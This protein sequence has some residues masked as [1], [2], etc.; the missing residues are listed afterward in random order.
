MDVGV[1]GERLHRRQQLR[2]LQERELPRAEV[3]DERAERLGAQRD[4]RAAPVGAV[5]VERRARRSGPGVLIG[6][7]RH[8]TCRRW[9]PLP[10]GSPRPRAPRSRARS[11]GAPI[12]ADGRTDANCRAAR[13]TRGEP[14]GGRLPHRA[15]RTGCARDP[16]PASRLPRRVAGGAR[17]RRDPPDGRGVRA[18]VR[19]RAGGGG[20]QRA[21]RRPQRPLPAGTRPR[22]HPGRGAVGGERAADAL[23]ARLRAGADDG[24]ARRPPL[25]AGP[26]RR[27]RHP[28]APADGPRGARRPPDPLD[29]AA[30][31]DG[32]RARRGR[33]GA[34]HRARAVLLPAQRPVPRRPGGRRDRRRRGRP[35]ARRARPPGRGR[36]SAAPSA[37]RRS[38]WA[39]GVG[40]STRRPG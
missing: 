5:G 19:A 12:V 22:T 26:G 10:Q 36:C 29:R 7:S 1:L 14:P 24:R 11:L 3:V 6:A 16:S 15:D 18:P 38:S 2:R 37:T 9:R 31:R 39:G 32:G 13:P 27:L 28:D 4:A 21:L 8:R 40:R 35:R 34:A 25:P 23:P 17:R 33:G 20:R 30:D